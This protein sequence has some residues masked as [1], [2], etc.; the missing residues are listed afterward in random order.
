MIIL[1]LEEIIPVNDFIAR[2]LRGPHGHAMACEI[3][4]C[5]ADEDLP[6]TLKCMDRQN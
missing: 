5:P 3:V 6:R 4:S 2:A 1:E